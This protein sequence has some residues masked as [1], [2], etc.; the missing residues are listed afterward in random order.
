[1][2]VILND[3]KLDHI[4]I[5]NNKSFFDKD[6]FTRKYFHK[7]GI[8]N[9]IFLSTFNVYK[10]EYEITLHGIDYKILKPLNF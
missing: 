10:T 1:M 4:H 9:F 3:E 5:Y 7:I 6:C 2:S 8:R